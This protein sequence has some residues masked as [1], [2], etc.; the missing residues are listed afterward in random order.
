MDAKIEISPINFDTFIVRVKNDML[1]GNFVFRGQ[2]SPDWGLETS[3]SRFCQ[4]HQIDFSINHFYKMLDDFIYNV[5]DFA[6]EELSN[7]KFEQKIAFAQHHG[8]YTP[9]LDWSVSPYVAI[10]FA[11]CNDFE[12]EKRDATFRVWS[13]NIEDFIS[14]DPFNFENSKDIT[15]RLIQSQVFNSRRISRQQGC[16]TFQNFKKGLEDFEEYKSNLKQYDICGDR[17][18]I[19][20]ELKM[21]GI[22][23]GNMFDSI[24]SI[25]KDIIVDDLLRKIF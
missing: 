6:G 16:F 9:F 22:T 13:F 21:M 15:F 18:S 20:K 17:I 23:S 10:F 7:M 19:L 3:Y 11:L 5:S 1:R 2:S 4:R 14:S 24:D 8:L 12:H 25:A